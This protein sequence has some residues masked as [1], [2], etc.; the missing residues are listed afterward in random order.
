M[1]T[2]P[3]YLAVS[4]DP[5]DEIVKPG[6]RQTDEV[7]QRSQLA[8][9]KFSKRRPGLF[10]PEFVD[11][12]GVWFTAEF[13]L[14]QDQSEIEEN[15]ENKYSC[16]GTSKKHNDLHLEHQKM[17]DIFHKA[18]TASDYNGEILTKSIIQISESI[19][20]A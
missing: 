1:D 12:R 16:K 4:G 2:D 10:K 15:E 18:A 3:F 20:K 11:T 5:L 8:T 7:N 9:N 6:L 14:M 17:L 13:Y 19:I